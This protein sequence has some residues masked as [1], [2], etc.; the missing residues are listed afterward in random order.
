[1]DVSTL[2]KGLSGTLPLRKGLS[3]RLRGCPGGRGWGMGGPAAKEGTGSLYFP[4]RSRI[5]LRLLKCSPDPA[6]VG[7]PLP[8]L[9]QAAS[10]RRPSS[11]VGL[12]SPRHL[13]APRGRARLPQLCPWTS[14]AP[15]PGK[16]RM[17]AAGQAWLCT[18]SGSR[19]GSEAGPPGRRCA[20]GKGLG[21]GVKA[22]RSSFDSAI[23]H[24]KVWGCS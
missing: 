12:M 23:H 5:P 18:W 6:P 4:G 1:M 16:F 2:L 14:P 3:Q 13:W 8:S 7:Q 11:V 10:F 24:P 22:P 9:L 21:V 20:L 15:P 17:W 19:D